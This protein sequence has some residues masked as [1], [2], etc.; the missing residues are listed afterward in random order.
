MAIFQKSKGHHM[1]TF[2]VSL[3]NNTECSVGLSVLFSVP[4]LQLFLSCFCHESVNRFHLSGLLF[5]GFQ[6]KEHF[7]GLMFIT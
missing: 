5:L 3:I 1:A 2:T 7:Q 6:R 4:K